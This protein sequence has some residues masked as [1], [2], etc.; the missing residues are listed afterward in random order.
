MSKY[1]WI[2]LFVCSISSL[3]AFSPPAT[4]TGDVYTSLLMHP[5]KLKN[6]MIKCQTIADSEK[7]LT[8]HCEVVMKAMDQMMGLIEEQQKQPEKFGQMILHAQMDA[9]KSDTQENRDKVK[10]LLSV[11]GLSSPE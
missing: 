10:I 9:A 11:V 1:S 2:I 5:E 8:S 7:P 6:E 4:A 3:T